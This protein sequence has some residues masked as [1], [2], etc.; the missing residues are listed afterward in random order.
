VASAL[1]S[2]GNH[3]LVFWASA[4]ALAVHDLSVWGH[5]TADG[6]RVFIV[7]GSYFVA[8]EVAVFFD[9]WNVFIALLGSHRLI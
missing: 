5:E 2:C 9:N 1:Q 3:A 7:H 8:A 4:G 6:L